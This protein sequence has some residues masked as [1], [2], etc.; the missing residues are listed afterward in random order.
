MG[1][2][3][4]ALL[5][6]AA[7]RK[8]L[9]IRVKLVD[10]EE[11]SAGGDTAIAATAAAGEA[12]TALQY[13]LEAAAGPKDGSSTISVIWN[14]RDNVKY[15]QNIMN[16]LL[17]LIES[18]KNIFNW[19]AP[20]KTYPIYLCLVAVWVVTILIPGRILILCLGLYQFLYVLIP[21]AKN[22]SV[23]IK[24]F[25]FLKSIP[26]DDDLDQVYAAEKKQ[27]VEQNRARLVS[28]VNNRKL[29]LCLEVLWR[30]LVLLK[31]SSG[32]GTG[33][34]SSSSTTSSGAPIAQGMASADEW[35]EVV[36]L[37]QGTRLVWWQSEGDLELQSC[38]VTARC[39]AR[40]CAI[41]SSL[42]FCGRSRW[43][44]CCCGDT[45]ES[46]S[47]RRST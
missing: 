2:S 3:T 20:H 5:H 23:G 17:D 38:K 35:S 39:V 16:W 29:E 4:K 10:A 8:Q 18:T 12:S 1:R 15:V 36:M 28:V 44:S 45:L 40:V 21:P 9:L 6:S 43:A 7:S 33:A 47:P 11:P 25:N 37:A 24:F 19:T 14:L 30:G 26:N 46:R 31:H 13:I 42:S 32:S 34:S 41:S 22:N 27:L